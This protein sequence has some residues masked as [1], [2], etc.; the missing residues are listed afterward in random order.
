[1]ETLE[2]ATTEELEKELERRKTSGG[3]PSQPLA[4]PDFTPLRGLVISGI[5]QAAKEQ[6]QDDDFKH[7]VYEAAV[8][9]VYGPTFWDWR[10][11][12]DW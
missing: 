6:F 9:A 7:Y 12:Q 3:L 2:D 1:M 5:E 11:K 4:N 10:N 8:T